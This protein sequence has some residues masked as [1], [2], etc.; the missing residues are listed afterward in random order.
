MPYTEWNGQSIFYLQTVPQSYR[1]TLLCVHGAGGNSRHWAYQLNLA[2][3]LNLRIIAVD[4]PGHGRS[5]GQPLNTI[6]DYSLFLKDLIELL[7]VKHLSLMGHSMGSA[8]CLSLAANFPFL[9]E[10]LILI[11]T[12]KQFKV[13]P[14]LL[15]GL[16]KGDRPLSFVEL[17]YHK[18]TAEQVLEIAKD[19][20][21]KTPISVLLND[22]LACQAFN[23][24]RPE[25]GLRI[26]CLLLFGDQ[27]R[28][29][30]VK[31]VEPLVAV[32]PNHRLSIIPEAGH[33]VMIEQPAA[34][35]KE[36]LSFLAQHL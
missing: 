27:D 13:A 18:N 29:T 23:F 24:D 14:W 35:N 7:E 34:I 4:L 12:A 5:T 9:V 2:K 32:L 25:A 21:Q 30:P 3:D 11:G 31:Y 22:F 36:I 26:P 28:L 19:E 15:D 6:K 20:F 16:K 33:M 10:N 8:I 17:A 1:G